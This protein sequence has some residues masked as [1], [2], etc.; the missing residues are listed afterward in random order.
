MRIYSICLPVVSYKENVLNILNILQNLFFLNN[1][2]KRCFLIK[3]P[4]VEYILLRT[5]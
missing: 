5:M 3:D 1:T 4:R 2:I